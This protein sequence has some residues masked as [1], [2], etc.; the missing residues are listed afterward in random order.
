M[1]IRLSIIILLSPWEV[2]LKKLAKKLSQPTEVPLVGVSVSSL[3][4][5]TVLR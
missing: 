1:T 5:T 4:L 2:E 3:R